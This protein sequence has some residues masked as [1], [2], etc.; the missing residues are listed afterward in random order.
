MPRHEYHLVDVFT[1]QKFGGNPLAVFPQAAEI[2]PIDMQRIARELNL[3]ETTFVLP[4]PD[5]ACDHRLRIFTPGRELQMAGHPTI[6]SAF[7]LAPPQRVVFLEGVG[8]I[9]VERVPRAGAELWRMTQPLPDWEPPLQ[10]RDAVATALGLDAALL[11]SDLPVQALSAGAP[12]LFVPLRDCEAVALARLN[13]ERWRS[14]ERSLDV[15]GVY[16]FALG[17]RQGAPLRARMFAPAAGVA[18][19]PGDRQRRRAPRLLSAALRRPATGRPSLDRHRAGDRDGPP[20]PDPGRDR[21]RPGRVPRRARRRTV[22]FR[23]WRIH[24]SLIQAVGSVGC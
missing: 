12:F 19:G 8:P 21:G 14:L 2:D 24:R 9:T 4:S 7:A 11:R 15:L 13:S 16:C 3:S 6:G 1:S 20:E 18:G 22:R 10:D 17:E 5:P 23:R